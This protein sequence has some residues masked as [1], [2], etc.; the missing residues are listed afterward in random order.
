MKESYSME[1]VNSIHHF[2]LQREWK[3]FFDKDRE[4]FHFVLELE[5]IIKT[6]SYNICIKDKY[7]LVYAVFPVGVDINNSD[8]MAKMAEFIC[9]AN[10]GLLKGNFEFDLDRGEILYKYYVNCDGIIPTEEMIQESILCPALMFEYYGTKILDIIFRN[11]TPV[12]AINDSENSKKESSTDLEKK[13]S[14]LKDIIE[15]LK[16]SENDLEDNHQND[17][18]ESSE[19]DLEEECPDMEID[20]DEIELDLLN[21]LEEESECKEEAMGIEE[22]TEDD[23]RIELFTSEEE[24]A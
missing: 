24:E 18:E 11:L 2:L 15:L 20:W 1:L 13:W 9:R 14:V 8:M 7:Y 6:I 19:E 16:Q 22:K 3:Y 17:S 21:D 5:N 4:V 23:I 10:C 12:S